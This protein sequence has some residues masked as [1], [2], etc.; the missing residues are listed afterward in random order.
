MPGGNGVF[1]PTIVAGGRVVGTWKRSAKAR[2]IVVEPQPFSKLPQARS[3]GRGLWGFL[4]KPAR[5]R[6]NELDIRLPVNVAV[7]SGAD[8]APE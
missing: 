3:R 7:A 6:L 1:K 2:E 5:L 8:A 4:G